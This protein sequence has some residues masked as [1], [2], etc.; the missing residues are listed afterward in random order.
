MEKD[1]FSADIS[2]EENENIKS[3][4][5]TPV[6]VKFEGHGQNRTPYGGIG[7]GVPGKGIKADGISAVEPAQAEAQLYDSIEKRL[8]ETRKLIKTSTTILICV[9]A[10]MIVFCGI[11]CI[12]AAS[13]I[14]RIIF[15]MCTCL[16]IFNLVVNIHTYMG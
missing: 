9:S 11:Q 1:V 12:I 7:I 2:S 10:I 15:L 6:F 8:S 5:C 13:A 3:T 4:G 16:N 14:A